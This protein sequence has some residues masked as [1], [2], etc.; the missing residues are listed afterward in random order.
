MHKRLAGCGWGLQEGLGAGA[1]RHHHDNLAE[2]A[3]WTADED[4][5]LLDG[6]SAD[7]LEL[8]ALIGRKGCAA[9]RARLAYLA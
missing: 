2:A 3:V 4:T 8:R 9:V 6:T 1:L 5:L 7:E